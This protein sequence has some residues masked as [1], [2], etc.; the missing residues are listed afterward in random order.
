MST[1]AQV[2]IQLLEKIPNADT[3]Q[4]LLEPENLLYLLQ[5]YG[6]QK[7]ELQQKLQ[8]GTL[9]GELLLNLLEQEPDVDYLLVMLSNTMDTRVEKRVLFDKMMNHIKQMDERAASLP[10]V[11]PVV[12]TP[13]SDAATV[14]NVSPAALPLINLPTSSVM[15]ADTQRSPVERPT[16]TVAIVIITLTSVIPA[17]TLAGF[18]P[19]VILSQE[20]TAVI[21]AIGGAVAGALVARQNAYPYWKGVLIGIV[22]NLGVLWTTTVYVQA[23]TSLF[24]IEIVIPLLLGSLPALLLYV[25]LIG[26]KEN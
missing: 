14:P 9:P 6:H 10:K 7:D 18:F 20:I 4:R 3:L 24:K 5:Q 19:K 11:E 15:A 16:S 26:K 8:S 22:L 13:V 23:R 17:L 25:L 21:A 1:K 2:L 12:S